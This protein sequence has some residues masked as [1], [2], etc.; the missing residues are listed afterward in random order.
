MFTSK[1]GFTLVEIMIVVGIIAILAGI[2]L[3]GSSQFRNSANDA[4][5]KA[6]VQKIAAYVNL[7]LTK[8]PSATYGSDYSSYA[9]L[10]T[11]SGIASA[12]IP[13]D[14][15]TAAAYTISATQVTATLSDGTSYSVQF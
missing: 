14:P 3:V 10:A 13:V 7:C 1:K 15:T 12:S 4:R 8:K 5:R 6:D 11:C 2:F 9:Q